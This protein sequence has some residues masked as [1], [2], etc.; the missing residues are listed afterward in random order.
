[1]TAVTQASA[2]PGRVGD[3]SGERDRRGVHGAAGA[4]WRVR[5]DERPRHRRV[6]GRQELEHDDEEVRVL[7]GRLLAELERS[8]A[9]LRRS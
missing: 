3:P 6:R 5:G 1:M 9:S 7:A 4:S 8:P 2:R